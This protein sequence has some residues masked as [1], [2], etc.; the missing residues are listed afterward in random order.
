MNF[1]SAMGYNLGGTPKIGLQLNSGSSPLCS[2]P[3]RKF[4][5]TSCSEIAVHW[6]HVVVDS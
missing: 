3:R 1:G 5:Q 2:K 4:V 6:P